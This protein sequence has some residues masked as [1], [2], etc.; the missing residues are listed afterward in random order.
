MGQKG[1]LAPG[2]GKRAQGA[3][4]IQNGPRT[5]TLALDPRDNRGGG[6]VV[7]VRA[8]AGEGAVLPLQD[9]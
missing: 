4:L 7:H 6:V 1:W 8:P 2:E 9:R 5:A 3:G